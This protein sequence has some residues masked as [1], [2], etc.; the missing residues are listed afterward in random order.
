VFVQRQ[1]AMD[2]DN[3]E[4]QIAAVDN[5]NKKYAFVSVGY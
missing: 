3:P 1:G 2:P 5:S 4:S